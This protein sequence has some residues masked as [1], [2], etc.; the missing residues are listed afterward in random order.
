MADTEMA[1]TLLLGRH[2]RSELGR[3]PEHQI[4]HPVLACRAHHWQQGPRIQP[5]EDLADHEAS[6]VVVRHGGDLR[7]DLR[8]L[9]SRWGCP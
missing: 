6:D 7:P 8:D 1:N 2:S 5:A 4:R 3:I 9:F